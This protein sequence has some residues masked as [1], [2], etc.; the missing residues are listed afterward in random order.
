[1]KYEHLEIEK[2]WQEYWLKNKTFKTPDIEKID[3]SKP[4]Y[5]ILDMLPYPSGD[6]LHVGHPEG[7]T[8]T[9]IISR[10]KRMKGFN[11]LHPMGWDAFGLPA[12]QFAIKKEINPKIGVEECVIR[13][14]SQ[15]QSLGFSYDWDREIN[16]TD[17]KYYKWTQWMFLKV[18]NSY[19]DAKEFK[20]K[21][22]SELKI[23]EGL[24]EKE[25][26]DFINSHRLAFI[27]E[28]PVNWCPELGTVLAN[29]EVPEQIEKGFTVVRRPMKQWKLRIT[30]YAQRLLE[31]LDSVNWPLSV[32]KLQ[33]NWIGRS[34][35]AIVK[36]KVKSRRESEIPIHRDEIIERELEVFT[37]RPDTLFGATYMVLAPEH[38]LIDEITTDSHKEKVNKYIEDAS[39]KSDLE[40]TELAK[41]KTGEFT[42]AYAINP[43]NQKEIPI[44]ISDYVLTSYGT[45]AIMS[46]PGHDE[47][48]MEFALKFKLEIIPVV[49]PEK[50]KDA[51][52][53][54][55]KSD[56]GSEIIITGKALHTL[57]G[58]TKEFGNFLADTINGKI[59]F[60]EEG[61]SINSGFI[62]GLPTKDA[63]AKM[64]KWLEEK[65]LGKKSINFKLRDWLFSRQR[66]WGEPFPIVHFEDGTYKALDESE[67]P[68]TL[69]EVKSYKASGTGESPLA[70]IPEW[71][72]TTDKETGKPVKRETNT[73]PQWAGSCWYYLRYIDPFNDK[74]FCDKGKDNYW[75]PVDLYIG[76]AEHAVLHLLYARFWHKVL[77]DLGYVSH[78]EPFTVLFN[79]GMIL[80]EDGV[81]MS[82]S[83]GNVINPDDVIKEFGADSMRLFEMF[84]G[85]L[86]STK[87]WSTEGMG[88]MF[89]FLNRVWRLVIDDRTGEI[90]DNVTDEKP[91][92]AQL[93][94]LHRAIKKITHDIEDG[95]MK[96][97]TS[98]AQ[99]M[100]FI[101]EI[102]KFEKVSKEII[103]KFL[104]LLSPFAP[105]IAEELWEKLGNKPSIQNQ[106]WPEWDD[107]YAK[108]DLITITFSVNGKMRSKKEIEADTNEKDLEQAAMDDPAILRHIMGKDIVKII[109]VKNRMVNIVVK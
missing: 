38:K 54:K 95:D 39:R 43:V 92:D 16:T 106:T 15:L 8:A 30:K 17:E 2:K 37:T 63:I 12:E 13:F 9:D 1:M 71:V 18:F 19:F 67:L 66:Y 5:Y 65:G 85:P 49:I 20:A 6:G 105:H 56:D 29:E 27:S 28:S 31:E 97:N 89:R 22:I 79:Q 64:N 88:G 24:S 57:N 41:N 91:D 78:N 102:Y 99:M 96:F 107:A 83:R 33:T 46:V 103:E 3:K 21:P 72:N 93:K 10:F 42:G 87:P 69:P 34:E 47:R 81:K 35:G 32:K 44:W 53:K 48:D 101:N 61:Y 14:R 76:G 68:V 23:P 109:V 7:Y 104:L 70:A 4:K 75:M 82:K 11:V 59:C 26:Y 73:M 108:N 94:I 58:D 77:F 40:R 51:G 52:I 50:F 98:I 90:K 55:I 100:I 74:I 25:K 80:G 84:M 36:F 62:S 60:T 45:G 86:E